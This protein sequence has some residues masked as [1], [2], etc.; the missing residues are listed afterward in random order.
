MK[1]LPRAAQRWAAR[2][3]WLTDVALGG[4]LTLFDMATVLGRTPEPAGWGVA[5]WGAQTVP[6][7]WRRSRPRACLA[8]MTCWYMAFQVLSPIEGRIPGPFLLMIGVYAAARYAPVRG[9]LPGTLLCLAC[10]STADALGG[11]WQTPGLGSL[12]PISAT[13]FVFFFAL[14]WL[15]GCGRRRIDADAERL[16]E[17]NRR[18]A[19]EQ[20]RNA[21]QAVVGERARIARDLHDVVAHHVSA[22]AVQARAAE[23]VM[24]P[25][26]VP[27]EAVQ[28]VGLIGRTADTAL[29]EMRRVLGLLSIRE[30]E[31]AP[32]PSLEHLEPLVE[33][34]TAA[35]CRVT[36]VSG[37]RTG[38]AFSA[39]MRLSVYRVVQEALTNVVRHAGPVGVRVAVA[40][41]DSRLTIDVVNDAAPAGHVPAP[42]TGQGLVGMRE[43]V[44]AFDGV[45]EA[46]PC[47]GGGWRL[48]AVLHATAPRPAQAD[49]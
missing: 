32:E 21:R 46:G 48:H 45:L 6:L 23:E 12:E 37:Y 44:L 25:A 18:L 26:S 40:G 17:L 22:I 20:D 49:A 1:A 16:R 11:H 28:C 15:L 7:L 5:L 34:A 31:L 9:S 38:S 33:A 39:G 8:A 2:R 3:P 42:G 47:E 10:T 36:F 27:A 24:A 30:R 19:A 35:G 4:G 13:T 43:R 14:A 41:D 29:L